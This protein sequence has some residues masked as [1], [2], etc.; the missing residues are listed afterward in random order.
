MGLERNKEW[1]EA[2]DKLA[3]FKIEDGIYVGANGRPLWL[4]GIL[5]LM[6]PSKA[7]TLETAIRTQTKMNEMRA[8]SSHGVESISGGVG[9]GSGIV[10]TSYSIHYTKL[11]GFQIP[12]QPV[13]GSL[14]DQT[15]V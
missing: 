9:W 14:A 7:V 6:P 8:A 4:T 3:T 12:N 10:I 13:P 1:D 5:G 11:L 2:L 15:I